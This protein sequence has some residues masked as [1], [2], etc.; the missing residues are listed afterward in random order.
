M[1]KYDYLKNILAG[2]E[3]D[4]IKFY[5]KGNHAAGTRIRKQLQ[6]LKRAANDMRVEI[7]NVKK[8]PGA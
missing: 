5:E 4:I 2:M 6:D 3:P 7:Q 8:G 1:S